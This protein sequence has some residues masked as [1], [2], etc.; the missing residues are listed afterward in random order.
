MIVTILASLGIQAAPRSTP[1][2]IVNDN[3]TPVPTTEAMQREPWQ[4]EL[5]IGVLPT[6]SPLSGQETQSLFVPVDKWLIIETITVNFVDAYT[7]ILT[8]PELIGLL[9]PELAIGT[10]ASGESAT[11]RFP[12]PEAF[13]ALI[14]CNINTSECWNEKVFKTHINTRLYAD[15]GST[16]N[17]IVM[18]SQ[19]ALETRT[20]LR[21]FSTPLPVTVSLSGYLVPAGSASFG[22]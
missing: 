9:I 20:A 6:G 1:V 18:L 12:I 19:T 13:T 11:H 5:T 2:T 8:F 15:P 3:A 21:K 10:T 17:V 4:K 14:D 16:V 7:T 22:H